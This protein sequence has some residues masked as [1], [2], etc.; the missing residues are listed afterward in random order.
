[1]IELTIYF[2][3]ARRIDVELFAQK[4]EGLGWTFKM[5]LVGG[6]VMMAPTDGILTALSMISDYGY[7][8]NAD[9]ESIQVA[10]AA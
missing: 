6:L 5:R 8:L 7:D 10:Q 4:M 2:N 3:P 1:M 9:F